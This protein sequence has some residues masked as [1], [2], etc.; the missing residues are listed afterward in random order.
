M[1][2]DISSF[3]LLL[4]K[5]IETTRPLF[6]CTTLCHVPHCVWLCLFTSRTRWLTS[7]HASMLWSCTCVSLC[8]YNVPVYV[9]IKWVKIE[10]DLKNVMD[11]WFECRIRKLLAPGTRPLL[12]YS[13]RSPRSD[14]NGNEEE[15]EGWGGGGGVGRK[16]IHLSVAWTSDP[17]SQ[18]CLSLL[19]FL[20]SQTCHDKLDQLTCQ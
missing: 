12:T 13:L 11:E 4:L 2:V 15:E 18:L 20:R 10:A 8:M 7:I 19:V 6:V 17:S 14:R 3:P 16:T 9:L 1:I 5:A